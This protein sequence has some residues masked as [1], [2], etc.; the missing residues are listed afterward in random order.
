MT[1]SESRLSYPD[2]QAFLDAV[3]ADAVGA[4]RPFP[5]F[6]AA[7]QFR[8]RCHTLR[9]ICRQDNRKVYPDPQHPMHGRCEYDPIKIRDPVAGPDGDWWVYGERYDVG[10]GEIEA[11]SEINDASS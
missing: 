9:K 3:L 2:A 5:T 8:T 4:R 10:E 11:L 7:F 6:G 1:T